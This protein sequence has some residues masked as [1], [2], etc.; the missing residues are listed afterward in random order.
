VLTYSVGKPPTQV[1]PMTPELSRIDLTRA[2]V[3]IDGRTVC[4][5]FTF[6]RPPTEGDLDVSF[7]LHDTTE[8]FCCTTL[9]F[10]RTAGRL[11]VGAFSI[12]KSGRYQLA[13]TANAGAAV[14]GSTLVVTGDLADPSTWQRGAHRMP[15]VEN[16]GWSITTLYVPK[17]YGPSFGDW[18]PRHEALGQPFIRHRDGAIRQP[19]TG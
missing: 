19:G 16:L 8:P 15:E 12:D 4:A 3:Q 9:R 5:T 7:N 14:R 18:L 2:E 6:A 13:E 10:R 1:Q 11:E 17:K